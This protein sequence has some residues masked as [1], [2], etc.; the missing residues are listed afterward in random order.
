V[1]SDD[2]RRLL[3]M[4]SALTQ[5]GRAKDYVMLDTASLE[6]PAYYSGSRKNIR[7]FGKLCLPKK[8][9]GSPTRTSNALR[10]Q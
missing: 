9:N 6:W 5:A 2:P 4:Q 8:S 1:F 10:T 3:L 7:I